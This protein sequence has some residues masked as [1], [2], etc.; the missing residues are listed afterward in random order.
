MIKAGI[1]YRFLRI[2]V[3]FA[4]RVF[5]KKIYITNRH[6]LNSEAPKI[7]A[8]NHPTAFLD[9]IF[10]AVT[11]QKVMHF[12]IRGDRFEK[13]IFKKLLDLINAVPIYRLRDGFSKVKRGQ[14]FQLCY[15]LLNKNGNLIIL[16]EG[17][18]KYE[19]RLRPI[20]RGTARIAFGAWEENGNENLE[21]IPVGVNYTDSHQ[22]RSEVMI[23]YGEPIFLNKYLD[24][25]KKNKRGAI[26]QLTEDIQRS[27]RGKVVHVQDP[28]NDDLAN[29]LLDMQRDDLDRERFPIIET[30]KNILE[31]ELDLVDKLNQLDWSEKT[32]LNALLTNYQELLSKHQL[33]DVGLSNSTKNLKK[34][35]PAMLL[36]A[37]VL[38]LGFILNCLP[39]YASQFFADA[40]IKQIEFHA[41]VRFVA[42]LVFYLIYILLLF[43]IGW[44]IIG[45]LPAL[46][47]ILLIMFLG[48]T[49]LLIRDTYLAWKERMMFRRL[50][51]AQQQTLLDAREEIISFLQKDFGPG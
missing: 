2:I 9:P 17:L 19:K 30:G 15:D 4:L 29:F 25:Y 18:T 14:S 8:V 6:I 23:E 37:L 45:F 40:N 3:V 38:P 49:T 46:L 43:G 31:K 47:A 33:K 44:T 41:P 42:G 13:K 48:F 39:L 11:S 26:V 34:F 21:V 27:L 35:H 32:D 20:Q 51:P 50:D 28:A 22:F 5:Y 36:S 16:S 1:V 24:H 10:I 7:L 12:Q